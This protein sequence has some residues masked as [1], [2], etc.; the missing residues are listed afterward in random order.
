MASSS[1]GPL[2]PNGKKASL[3]STPGHQDTSSFFKQDHTPRPVEAEYDEI[4]SSND[5]NLTNSAYAVP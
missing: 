3:Q 5:L 2:I 4:A 1:I